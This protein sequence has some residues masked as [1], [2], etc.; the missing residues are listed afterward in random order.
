MEKGSNN[1]KTTVIVAAI[2]AFATI[3][4]AV[5]G[6]YDMNAD[7]SPPKVSVDTTVV[8]GEKMQVTKNQEFTNLPPASN[9]NTNKTV[10]ASPIDKEEKAA[11][12]SA[13]TK[14]ATNPQK[15]WEENEVLQKPEFLNGGR[16]AMLR[17]ITKNMRY[18]AIA[19]ENGVEG[20]VI[21]KFTVEEDG[22]IANV[23]TIKGVDYPKIEINSGD[24]TQYNENPAKGS[25]EEEAIRLVQTMP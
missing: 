25:L 6:K 2:G 18:P 21:L 19:K 20:T 3:I 14:E 11:A 10:Q 9:A 12:N 22:S 7:K 13:E 4:A 23:Q 5:I 24:K 17:W 15:V 8:E 16:L 1:N